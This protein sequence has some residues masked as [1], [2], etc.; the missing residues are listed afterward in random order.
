MVNA[1][2]KTLRECP[3]FCSGARQDELLANSITAG[4]CYGKKKN[5][6]SAGFLWVIRN[7]CSISYGMIVTCGAVAAGRLVNTDVRVTVTI[8][9]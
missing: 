2:L 1:E 9:L 6:A 3:R 5:P 4:S 8:S 7:E